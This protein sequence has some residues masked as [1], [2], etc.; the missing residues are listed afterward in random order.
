MEFSSSIEME[1]NPRKITREGK[2]FQS[3]FGAPTSETPVKR[4]ATFGDC[5]RAQ[6]LQP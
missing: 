3:D 6:V 4:R 2:H 1:K 5:C